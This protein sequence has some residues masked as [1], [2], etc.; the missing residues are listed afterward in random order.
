MDV[1][2]YLESIKC[3]YEENDITWEEE[4]L[5]HYYPPAYNVDVDRGDC[6]GGNTTVYTLIQR[7][8]TL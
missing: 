1:E 4:F 3:Y 6:K 7:C 8:F 2:K 5:N